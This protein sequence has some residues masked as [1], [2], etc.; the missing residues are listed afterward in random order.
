MIVKPNRYLYF[1]AKPINMKL[2]FTTLFLSIAV[3]LSAQDTIPNM[4]KP[5]PVYVKPINPKLTAG[6]KLR[7]GTRQ[8]VGSVPVAII[9][10]VL[11][12]FLYYQGTKTTVTTNNG[13]PTTQNGNKGLRVAGIT[14]M[15]LFGGFSMVLFIS[16]AEK[17]GDAGRIL[18][19]K[20][21]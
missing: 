14:S 19:E 4:N 10:G 15:V 21:L 6:Y 8:L 9:G 20:G 2:L 5:V 7:T 16:G 12:G 3:L 13:I 11:G 1:A 18:Q 17:I